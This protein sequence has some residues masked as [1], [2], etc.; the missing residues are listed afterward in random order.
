[1]SYWKNILVLGLTA[2]LLAACS[3]DDADDLC[4]APASTTGEPDI[5]ASPNFESGGGAVTAIDTTGGTVDVIVNVPVDADT[6]SVAVD[7]IALGNASYTFLGVTGGA[8]L[9]MQGPAQTVPVTVTFPQTTA[10]N[11]YYPVIMLCND[12][13]TTCSGGAGYVEDPTDLISA[14]NYVRGT[15]NGTTV[16]TG[17]ALTNSCVGLSTLV[18]N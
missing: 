16:V 4:E 11:T 18:V 12:D 9:T 14:D 17:G 5:T 3:G 7:F 1:M 2:V 13:G 15:S 6:W 8:D 10:P